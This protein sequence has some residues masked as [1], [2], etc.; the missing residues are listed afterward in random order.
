MQ[1]CARGCWPQRGLSQKAW[2]CSPSGLSP[3]GLGNTS[4]KALG[5]IPW[6]VFNFGH[7]REICSPVA[8]GVLSW[9]LGSGAEQEPQTPSAG[10]TVTS[11]PVQL[12][13]PPPAAN[14]DTSPC[15]KQLDKRLRP[16]ESP[17]PSREGGEPGEVQAQRVPAGRQPPGAPSH[18]RRD[19]HRASTSC[20]CSPPPVHPDPLSLQKQQHPRADFFRAPPPAHTS[21]SLPHDTY[22]TARHSRSRSSCTHLWLQ[23]LRARS[24]DSVNLCHLLPSARAALVTAKAPEPPRLHAMHEM[25]AIQAPKHA[26]LKPKPDLIPVLAAPSHCCCRNPPPSAPKAGPAVFTPRITG[27]AVA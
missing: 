22:S 23:Q 21:P 2:P 5:L 10:S 24:A 4:G 12:A 16:H 17:F 26:G 18:C 11:S 13:A 27:L 3:E 15:H 6:D 14:W 1:R 25:P 8:A 9:L 7:P 19:G 20:L